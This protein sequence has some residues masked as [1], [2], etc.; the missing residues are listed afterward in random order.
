MNEIKLLKK[1][2]QLLEQLVASQK[3][4]ISALQ[5]PAIRY[6]YYPQYY[7]SYPVYYNTYPQFYGNA[8]GT[9]GSAGN[10]ATTCE[11]SL[12]NGTAANLTIGATSTYNGIG[13]R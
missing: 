6:V 10:T 2:I 5:T 9:T 3:E 12:Y 1:Q 8:G 11:T 7:G 4:L 13:S